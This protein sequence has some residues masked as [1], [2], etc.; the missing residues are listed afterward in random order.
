[1]TSHIIRVDLTFK[2]Q[3]VLCVISG[4]CHNTNGVCVL[5]GSYA[6]CSGNSI[7]TLQANISVLSSRVKKCYLKGT[8]LLW[9]FGCIIYEWSNWWFHFVCTLMKQCNVLC[10]HCYITTIKSNNDSLGRNCRTNFFAVKISCLSNLIL[11]YKYYFLYF[12]DR[13]SLCITT[14]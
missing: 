11:L 14:A 2:K 8:W 10:R 4:C 7:L 12:V 5:L 6:A 9:T 1:M 3:W 13:I